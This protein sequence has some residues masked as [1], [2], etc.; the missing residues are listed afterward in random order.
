MSMH[1][2]LTIAFALSMGAIWI[3][4]P[5]IFFVFYQKGEKDKGEAIMTILFVIG[6]AGGILTATNMFK[7]EDK[8]IEANTRVAAANAQ[9]QQIISGPWEVR[10]DEDLRAKEPYVALLL[11]GEHEPPTS[12]GCFSG[13]NVYDVL[14]EADFASKGTPT[15]RSI[16]CVMSSPMIGREWN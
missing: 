2:L 12:I 14:T 1:T 3:A 5:V 10:E 13:K 11:N 9:I 7:V 4:G 15:T 6:V 8:Q 16:C